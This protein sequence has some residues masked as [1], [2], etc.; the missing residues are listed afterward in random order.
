MPGKNLSHPFF[1]FYRALWRM[2]KPFLK[3][4]ARLS[5]GW[6]ER[7]ASP[8][9]LGSDFPQTEDGRR[10]DVW[11]QAAS[12]GEARL[13]EAICEQLAPDIPMRMVI[14]TWTRQ[15]REIADAALLRLKKALPLL[16]A[17]TRFTPIDDPDC[18]SRAL[19]EARPRVVALLE[20][21][22][23][24]GL[25]AACRD[26]DIPVIVL[27]GRLNRSTMR[28]KN[29][30]PS[31][32]RRIAPQKILAVSAEDCRRYGAMFRCTAES[33][34]NIKFDLAMRSLDTPP[35]PLPLAGCFPAPVFL[36]ASVR[37]GEYRQLPRHFHA[38]LNRRQGTVI[39]A[40][41]HMHSAEGWQELME[42]LGFRVRLASTLQEGK[43]LEAGTVVI[44]DRF[45]DL[46]RLYA[47]ASAVFVGGTIA[48]GGQN[49]LEP[50]SAGIEPFIGPSVENFSW[51]LSREPAQSP[52]LEEAELVHM[53]KKPAE[54][55]GA[56]LDYSGKPLDRDAVRSRF[57]A[58]LAGR[59]G[60]AAL[61]AG[62]IQ[63]H[64]PRP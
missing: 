34:P 43:S 27:N 30:F 32:S 9:W 64:I 58:W 19:D 60:G 29:F 61:A 21:E 22:L 10:I 33:M 41:R 37:H 6:Q 13:A 51:A 54:I 20:T 56:M 44:W 52:S 49:F 25:M 63:R 2:A 3:R 53:I 26:R 15:G 5:D 46:P 16:H 7:I 45:G 11:L 17:A 62:E 39:I 14:A 57:R 18:V 55:I 42:D 31:L 28:F 48:Q 40:P 36:F 47:L 35:E 24:P 4:H 1:L 8:H 50:L 59:V 23:W 12:G 38:I